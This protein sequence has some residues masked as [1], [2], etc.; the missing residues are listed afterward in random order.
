MNFRRSGENMYNA[1]VKEHFLNPRNVGT[2]DAPDAVG[3]GI[4]E[5]DG[6]RVHL[7]FKIDDNRITDVKM[8]VSGCVA[9]IAATSQ[10]TEMLI[11]R[12]VDEALAIK[13][14]DL[15]EALGG[16]PEQKIKCSLTC[17]DAMQEALKS[18]QD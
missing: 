6:D 11:G 18:F 8:K 9:A 5:A 3:S 12:T 7:H 16:L 13:K 17:M 2:L 1:T 15:V 14:I 10:L 4:N